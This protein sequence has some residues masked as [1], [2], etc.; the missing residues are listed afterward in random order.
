MTTWSRSAPMKR[1][2]ARRRTGKTAGGTSAVFPGIGPVTEK[3]LNEIGVGSLAALRKLGAAGTYRR[4]KFQ[5]GKAVTLNALYG[6]E[7]VIRGCH[8]LDLPPDRKQELKRTVGDVSPDPK[9]KR[10]KAG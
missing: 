5:F 8:W 10:P 9:S 6:L 4:L 1:S 7:A 3:R 2:P